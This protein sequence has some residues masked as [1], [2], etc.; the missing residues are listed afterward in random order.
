MD[1]YIVSTWI[2]SVYYIAPDQNALS[3]WLKKIHR[4]YYDAF[5]VSLLLSQLSFKPSYVVV[6]SFSSSHHPSPFH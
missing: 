5:L 2:V 1:I 3:S 4:D 6:M